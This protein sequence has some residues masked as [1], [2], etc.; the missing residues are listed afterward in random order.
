M[1]LI[2]LARAAWRHDRGGAL[3]TALAF[4]ALPIFALL[5]ESLQ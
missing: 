4:A 1:T 5:L 3:A 2:E